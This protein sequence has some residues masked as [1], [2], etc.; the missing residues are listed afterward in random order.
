ML[1]Q[2]AKRCGVWVLGTV[3][4]MMKIDTARRFGADHVINYQRENFAE[5]VSALTGGRG[6]DA[7][8]DGVG[9]ATCKD[10]TKACALLADW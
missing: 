8:I 3:V 9:A 2:L 4:Q 1:S 5:A 10:D 7:V 6:V